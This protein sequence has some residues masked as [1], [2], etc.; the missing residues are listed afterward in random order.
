MSRAQHGVGTTDVTVRVK[1]PN[2]RPFAPSFIVET[3]DAGRKAQ[4]ETGQAG[5]GRGEVRRFVNVETD[6]GLPSQ[7]AEAAESSNDIPLDGV[8]IGLVLATLIGAA[9]GHVYAGLLDPRR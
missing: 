5:D 6:D 4:K 9:A 1:A 8:V 3:G 7:A 2:R